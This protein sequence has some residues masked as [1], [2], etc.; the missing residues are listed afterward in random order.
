MTE[1][2]Q[3][4]QIGELVKQ[5][6]AQ[7]IAL[8]HLKLKGKNIADAYS[9]FAFNRERWMVD[10]VTG[11]GAVF[12]LRPKPEERQ[13]PQYLLGQAELA[14]YIRAKSRKLN[15]HWSLRTRNLPLWE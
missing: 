9:A 1:M 14:Q 7:K 15:K 8:E 6:Q 3:N 11:T 2:E 12:L 5:R 4:A 10:D 13:H